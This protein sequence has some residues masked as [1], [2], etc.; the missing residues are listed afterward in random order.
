[1]VG[2]PSPPSP[3]TGGRQEASLRTPRTLRLSV[4]PGQILR[5]APTASNTARGGDS[6]DAAATCSAAGQPPGLGPLDSGDRANPVK[7]TGWIAEGPLRAGRPPSCS[8]RLHEPP[9]RSRPP[10]PRK[11]Q[12]RDNTQH[13]SVRMNPRQSPG[14]NP[15]YHQV[16]GARRYRPDRDRPR[17][18]PDRLPPLPAP[19]T[20]S[21]VT[22]AT[23]AEMAA[24]ELVAHVLAELPALA[25]LDD[26]DRL[27][28]AAWLASPA[29]GP[30]PPLLR[31]GSARLA[32]VAGRA[33]ARAA[34]RDAGCRWICGCAPSRP[35]APAT[36][37]C[38]GGCRGSGR[39]T[40]TA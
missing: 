18:R 37:R 23:P 35:A 12:V 7:Y 2:S 20:A 39:S 14:D 3:S 26:R 10:G 4:Q 28:A 27:L 22:S 40:G 16:V 15:L 25:V 33:R 5:F 21:I 6:R 24:G 11:R 8:S 17:P 19:V 30:H 38:G 34:R 29:L 13:P 1:M 31:R 32:G 36:R 9:D